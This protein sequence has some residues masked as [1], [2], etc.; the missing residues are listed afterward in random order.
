MVDGV[1]EQSSLMSRVHHQ[2]YFGDGG[3]RTNDKRA[4]CSGG[5]SS[6]DEWCLAG[7]GRGGVIW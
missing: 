6:L 1:G 7:F 4:G 2:R 3:C 5:N